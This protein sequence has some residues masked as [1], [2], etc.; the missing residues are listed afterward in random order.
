MKL[1]D[2]IGDPTEKD[3]RIFAGLQVIFFSVIAYLLSKKGVSTSVV[4]LMVA[5]STVVGVMGIAQP[6]WIRPIYVGWMVAVFPI[7]WTVSHLMM[8]VV[9]YF[10]VTPIG[11]WRTRQAGDPMQR[12]YDTDAET[13][14]EERDANKP[15]ES[16]FRQF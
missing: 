10:V 7:G 15:P 12:K 9:Y 2:T 4:S 14:W 11:L 1:S 6:K 3:L 13:Y 16:Y 8:A 5:V